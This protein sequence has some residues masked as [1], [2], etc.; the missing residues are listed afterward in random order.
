MEK[1]EIRSEFWSGKW[2]NW[3]DTLKIGLRKTVYLCDW[4]EEANNQTKCML[5]LLNARAFLT[6]S[7]KWAMA[8]GSVNNRR[9]IYLLPCIF[10]NVPRL[11]LQ[12]IQC[13][14]EPPTNTSVRVL[15]FLHFPTAMADVNIAIIDPIGIT[16]WNTALRTEQGSKKLHHFPKTV[17]EQRSLSSPKDLQFP[18]GVGWMRISQIF[19]FFSVFFIF[20]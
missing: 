6:A 9:F 3:N 2:H 18:Y 5:M 12:D 20:L 11:R 14:G 1:L 19:F 17:A 7:I 4:T 13:K 15:S 8:P 10:K 16:L